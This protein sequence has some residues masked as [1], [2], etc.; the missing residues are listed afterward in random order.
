MLGAGIGITAFGTPGCVRRNVAVAGRI[1]C[2]LGCGFIGASCA[3][4]VVHL[5][6]LHH[7]VKF[8]RSGEDV[9]V[10]GGQAALKGGAGES[11]L[12]VY[13]ELK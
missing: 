12:D 4:S 7:R 11:K 5:E 3:V 9:R 2:M 13:E 1:L 8:W 10:E 6:A